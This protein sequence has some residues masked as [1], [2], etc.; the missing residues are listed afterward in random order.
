MSRRVLLVQPSLQPPGGG[1][2]VAAWIL[3]ALVPDHTVTI[4]SWRPVE[5]EPINRFFGTHLRHDDFQN[6]VVPA[7]WRA[8]PDL[9]PVPLSLI[10]SSMLMRYTRRVS[11]GYDVI[12]GVNNENDYGRRGIQYIHFPT[13]LRPRPAVD[14]RWYHQP[15]ALL[16][17]YYALADR[18]AGFSLD[19]LRANVSL[20]NSDWTA[21]HARRMIG[22]DARTVYPPVADPAPPVPWADRTPGFLA[23]GRLSPEKEYERLIRIVGRVRRHAP[24]ATLTIVGTSDRHGRRY[25]ESLQR[26]AG[27]FGTM[28]HF[29]LDLTRADIREAIAGH[30]YGLHGMREEHFGMAPAEMV[31]GGTIVWVPRGGGQMEIVGDEPALLYENEEEAVE[32]ILR[33]MADPA[34][35][36]RLRAQLA[37]RGE[38]FSTA[39]FVAEIREIVAAFEG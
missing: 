29:R 8:V 7:S 32:K 38:R 35:Q 26:L 14:L 3:Q 4:V 16:T 15:R 23:I 21:G 11:D 9:C 2:G 20:A 17:M 27:E 22:L 12:I 36:A 28:V 39:R 30:R 37:T 34:E 33:V 31:R 25:F 1:N 10:K 19:R 24:G 5:V 18:I 6:L 13:Y